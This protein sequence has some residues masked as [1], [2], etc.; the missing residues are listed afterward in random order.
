M[1]FITVII[2]MIG[3]CLVA[4][5]V[6]LQASRPMGFPRQEYWCGL[7]FPSPGDLPNSSTKPSSSAS[8]ELAG[9]FFTAEPPGKPLTKTQCSQKGKVAQLEIVV[10]SR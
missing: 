6:A 7:P 2:F 5:P 3:C 8:P 10:V 1:I 9:R 4:K